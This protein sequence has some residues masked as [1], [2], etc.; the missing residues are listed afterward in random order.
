MVPVLRLGL[1]VTVLAVTSACTTTANTNG[2]A[3]TEQKVTQVAATPLSD[4]NLVKQELPQVLLDSRENPYRVPDPLTCETIRTQLEALTAALGPDWDDPSSKVKGDL[5]EDSAM[6]ALQSAVN[7]V[8]PFRSWV[9]RLTGADR[10]AKEVTAA[11]VAGSLRRSYLRGQAQA[12]Q[13]PVPVP[14]SAA[15]AASAAMVGQEPKS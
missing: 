6:G 5:L 8:V 15:S 3:S 1:C 2:R 13:C 4:F 11:I 10:A 14:A 12:R 7:G 9:R